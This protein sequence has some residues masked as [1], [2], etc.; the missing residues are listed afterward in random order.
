M[1]YPGDNYDNNG[2]VANFH[3]RFGLDNTVYNEPGP[4]S[5]DPELIQFRAKFM[6]EELKEFNDAV[7]EQDHAKMFDA[8]IDLVYVAHGTAHLLGYPWEGGWAAVHEANMNKVR[9]ASDGSDSVRGSALD[10]VKPEGWTPPDI[11]GILNHYG[12]G[13]CPR[14]NQAYGDPAVRCKPPVETIGVSKS[15][16]C[17]DTIGAPIEVRA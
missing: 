7:A 4:R 3:H 6:A 15:G 1:P 10:V 12:F 5:W 11:A 16:W 2:D 13:R 9:A 8:L 17:L 14:C